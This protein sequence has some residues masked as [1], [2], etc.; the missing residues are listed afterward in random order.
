MCV[1]ER[2][3]WGGGE[4]ERVCVREGMCVWSVCLVSSTSTIPSSSLPPPPHT[5][6]LNP[7]PLSLAPSLQVHPIPDDKS[8]RMEMLRVANNYQRI[9]DMYNFDFDPEPGTV[10]YKID[11]RIKRVR[12][13][14]VCC[15]TGSLC[16]RG[17]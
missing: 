10:Q 2:L 15:G 1:R 13:A 3:C 17:G 5:H 12:E 8:I 11:Q 6:T 4:C 9:Y 14:G 7:H 16:V